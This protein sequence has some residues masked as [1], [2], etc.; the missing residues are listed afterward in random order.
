[1][2]SSHLITS[3]VSPSFIYD[4]T[5][6]FCSLFFRPHPLFFF[7][8]FLL[9][10]LLPKKLKLRILLFF[11]IERICGGGVH[12]PAFVFVFSHLVERGG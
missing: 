3:F 2:G 6:R 4:D 12:V 9:F 10:F 7:V 11:C 1:M 8:G 5:L